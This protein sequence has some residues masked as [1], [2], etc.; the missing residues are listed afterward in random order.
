MAGIC[1]PTGSLKLIFEVEHLRNDL[2]GFVG[3]ALGL[4]EFGHGGLPASIDLG[5][6]HPFLR[7]G[8]VIGFCV[9]DK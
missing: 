7:V 5:L 4:E 6:G 2:P 1:S 8:Q 3:S 9:A